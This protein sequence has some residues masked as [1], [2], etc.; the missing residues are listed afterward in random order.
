MSVDAV[1]HTTESG[2]RLVRIHGIGFPLPQF[3]GQGVPHTGIRF[4]TLMR[5]LCERN[6]GT[7]VGLSR[8]T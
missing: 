4:A 8:D 1:N 2:D 6:G 7:F 5:V 3:P